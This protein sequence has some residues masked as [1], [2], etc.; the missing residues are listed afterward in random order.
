MART[1]FPI[2]GEETL[3]LILRLL[4]ST[5]IWIEEDNHSYDAMCLIVVSAMRYLMLI[6]VRLGVENGHKT[7]WWHDQDVVVRCC[8]MIQAHLH[9]TDGAK[10]PPR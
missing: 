7:F 3:S 8:T 2:L 9:S 5:P 1:M 10:A 4:E 6:D